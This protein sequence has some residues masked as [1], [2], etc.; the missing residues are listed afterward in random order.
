M[1]ATV[2]PDK[3]PAAR[4]AMLEEIEKVQRELIAPEELGKAVKQF[5]SGTLSSR[6]TMLRAGAG[7][8]IELAFGRMT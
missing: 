7:P 4:D 1:S 2:D 5:V 6:K 8:G 3:F